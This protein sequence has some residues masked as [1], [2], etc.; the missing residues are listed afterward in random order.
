MKRFLLSLVLIAQVYIV[1]AQVK[2]DT[3]DFSHYPPS[4]LY[5]ETYL[6]GMFQPEDS[7]IIEV[8]SYA[9]GKDIGVFRDVLPEQIDGR[10]FF[11]YQVSQIEGYGHILHDTLNIYINLGLGEKASL[12]K[13][14]RFI[15]KRNGLIYRISSARMGYPTET[16]I[17]NTTGIQEQ[18]LNQKGFLVSN[19]IDKISIINNSNSQ[20]ANFL[21]F[22]FNGKKVIEKV[23]TQGETELA[24]HGHGI[25]YIEADG[26]IKLK[27]KF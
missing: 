3:I 8:G 23:I 9:D 1:N 13:S 26:E 19:A 17:L 16:E 25:Y 18:F 6:F 11:N 27:G 7:V 24:I 14:V 2:R 4:S 21:L 10:N 22:D 15:F 12:T 20:I 5:I